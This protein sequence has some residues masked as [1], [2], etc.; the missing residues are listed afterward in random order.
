MEPRG[1]RNSYNIMKNIMENPFPIR[2]KNGTTVIL[3]AESP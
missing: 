2:Y 1:S 3:R